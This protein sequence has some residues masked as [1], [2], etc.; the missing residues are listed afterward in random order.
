V[1]AG[2][3][4]EQSL[5]AVRRL[6]CRAV[7]LVGDN[8]S[9]LRDVDQ[10]VF[11]T[12]YAAFSYLFPKAAA[13]VHQGGIG[14]CGQALH[15]GVPS[16]IVPLGLDQPDNAFRM[17]RLGVARVLPRRRYTAEAAAKH[18]RELIGTTRYG[19]VARGIASK[20]RRERGIDVTCDAIEAVCSEAPLA[21]TVMPPRRGQARAAGS[22]AK[23]ANSAI[24]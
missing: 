24:N 22:G 6:G 11:V 7:F 17:Q 16:L 19:E 23:A 20:V 9:L 8:P 13:V 18:L 1:D 21:C 4:F 5:S 15:A 10:T 3:F 12:S 14:T 2:D